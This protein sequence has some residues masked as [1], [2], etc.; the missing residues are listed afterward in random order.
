M[1]TP[2][3]ITKMLLVCLA[4]IGSAQATLVDRG[5]G[6]VYDDVNNVTWLQDWFMPGTSMDWYAAQTWA[7]DL[8]F[9][10]HDDWRLPSITEFD[11]LTTQSGNLWFTPLFQNVA[12]QYWS[13]TAYTADTDIA[14]TLYVHFSNPTWLPK[15]LLG[16][17]VAVRDGDV[18]GTHAVPEPGGLALLLTATGAGV[19]ATRRRRAGPPD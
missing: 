12:S 17:V 2:K 11:T 14:W 10:G 8:A 9:G 18:D 5:G 4:G 7:G 13:S 19:L 6:M 15:E 3:T 1:L 16:Q